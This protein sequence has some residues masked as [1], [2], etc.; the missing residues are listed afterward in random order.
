M[1]SRLANKVVI[2][3]GEASGI[4]ESAVHIFVENG[5][6]VVIADIQDA[7]GQ[8]L[9]EKFGGNV[10]YIHC[11]VSNEEDVINL[12]DATVAKFG[13]VDVMY[14]N[15]GVVD[16]PL[17]T[18]L[19]TPKSEVERLIRVNLVGGFLGAKHAARVM[20]PR[21]QGCILFT[22]TKIPSFSGPLQ[23]M[24]VSPSVPFS[25]V[26]P[27]ASPYSGHIGPTYPLSFTSSPGADKHVR[28]SLPSLATATLVFDIRVGAASTATPLTLFS[29]KTSIGDPIADVPVPCL[30]PQGP[31][32]PLFSEPKTSFPSSIL[33]IVS[34]MSNGSEDSGGIT[35]SAAPP[36]KP[37]DTSSTTALST[38]PPAST[39]RPPPT[40]PPD[41]TGCVSTA[42]ISKTLPLI[43]ILKGRDTG[44]LRLAMASPAYAVTK[45]GIAGLVKNLAA[46]LG[47]FGIR[48]NCVSPFGV[49]TPMAEVSADAMPQVEEILSSANNLKGQILKPDDVARTALFLASEEAN[50]VS[51][52]NLV[53]DGG[54]SVVNPTFINMK[55]SFLSSNM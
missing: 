46:E 3:T 27:S 26:G 28:F 32:L 20:V 4:G 39:F 43:L 52:V 13:K 16:T 37:L 10:V 50:F 44:F 12:M 9:A 14:N 11:D 35:M 45:H 54:F 47:Q 18:I 6:K 24:L 2:I 30:C 17:A 40:S 33:L 21:G 25:S 8:A 55:A 34:I 48:V 15:A 42:N 49:L 5:A 29:L 31:F 36:P 1:V 22:A 19:E 7:K 23:L 41:T 53:V 51:G 38:V